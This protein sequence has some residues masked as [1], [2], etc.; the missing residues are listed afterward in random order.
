VRIRRH[1]HRQDYLQPIPFSSLYAGM[2]PGLGCVIY[3]RE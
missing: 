2:F 3:H 1:L